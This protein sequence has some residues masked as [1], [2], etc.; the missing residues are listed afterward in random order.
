MVVQGKSLK[1]ECSKMYEETLIKLKAN[2]KKRLQMCACEYTIIFR[3][4]LFL[5]KLPFHNGIF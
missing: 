1:T 5:N 4:I 2:I 3:Q